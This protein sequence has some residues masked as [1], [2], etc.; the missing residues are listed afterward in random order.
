MLPSTQ[1]LRNLA[2]F[3]KLDFAERL[4]LAE[5]MKRQEEAT[6][7]GDLVTVKRINTEIGEFVVRGHQARVAHAKFQCNER[8]KLSATL[9]NTIAG[10]LVVTGLV[11]PNLAMLGLGGPLALN[12]WLLLPIEGVFYFGNRNPSVGEGIAKEIASMTNSAEAM[13]HAAQD[14]VPPIILCSL[15]WLF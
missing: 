5:L 4:E 14:V 1:H 6:A 3:G 11:T 7:R 2:A 12:V 9:L 13:F 8:I 10:G 15:S